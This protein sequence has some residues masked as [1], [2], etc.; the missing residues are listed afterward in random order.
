MASALHEDYAQAGVPMLPVVIGVR[1][2]AWAILAHALA[3][4]ALSLLPAFG[5]GWIYLTCAATGGALFTWRSI[6]LVREPTRAR[7]MANFHASLL[8]LGLLLGAAI[9]DPLLLG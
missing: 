4:T 6:R 3:L 8:Q 2:T 9:A 5:L 7:A 1:A